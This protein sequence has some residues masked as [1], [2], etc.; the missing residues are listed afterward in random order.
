MEENG[1]SKLKEI[2]Y[3]ILSEMEKNKDFNKKI[4]DIILETADSAASPRK[5]TGHRRNSSIFNPLD[6]VMNND[7]NLHEK[8]MELDIEQLKD[9]IAEHGMDN[10]KLAMKWKSKERLVNLIIE[11][12][13]RRSTK[14]DA[15]RDNSFVKNQE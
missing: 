13:I 5:K 15:F 12:S 4:T 14:G 11:T 2:F 10:A 9:I 3:C 6:M 1:R 7:L 8:L